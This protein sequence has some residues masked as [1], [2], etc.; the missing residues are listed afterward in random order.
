MNSA[1]TAVSSAR[2][3]CF[4][5]TFSATAQQKRDD[6]IPNGQTLVISRVSDTVRAKPHDPCGHFR[7]RRHGNRGRQS[8]FSPTLN[9]RP[10]RTDRLEHTSVKAMSRRESCRVQPPPH[11]RSRWASICSARQDEAYANIVSCFVPRFALRDGRRE[12]CLSPNA[13][14]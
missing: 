7:R 12:G 13:N 14:A 10:C 11:L 5:G 1:K 2:C 6:R 3:S 9:Y 4:T 8:K